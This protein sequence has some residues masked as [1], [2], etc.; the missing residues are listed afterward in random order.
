[1]L[2]DTRELDVVEIAIGIDGSPLEH[3]IALVGSEAVTHGHQQIPKVI[4]LDEPRLIRIET[5]EGVPY[6]VLRVRPV[7]FLPEQREKHGEIDG[8]GGFFHHVFQVGVRRVFAKGSQHVVQ[9]FLVD[10]AVTVLVDHVERFL[11]LLDLRLVEHSE[12]V[13]R[14]SLGP[15][16]SGSLLRFSCGGGHFEFSICLDLNISDYM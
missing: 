1:M 16:L 13:G 5:P 10:E 12:H 4:L 15:L 11:E 9:V 14:R 6:H 2:E 3:I 7:Q 8:S